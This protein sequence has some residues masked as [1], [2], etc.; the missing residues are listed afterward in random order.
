MD[1]IVQIEQAEAHA[2]T[3]IAD[4]QQTAGDT[5]RVSRVSAE[6]HLEASRQ[7]TMKLVRTHGS[8]HILHAQHEARLL[9]LQGDRTRAD[10]TNT[11]HHNMEGAVSAAVTLLT[12]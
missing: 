8:K 1:K 4:A 7:E 12:T 5:L 10:L 2:Q 6:T 3:V 9:E 11:A